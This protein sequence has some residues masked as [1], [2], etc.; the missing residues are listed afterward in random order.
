LNWGLLGEKLPQDEL[1]LAEMRESSELEAPTISQKEFE[2]RGRRFFYEME[3]ESALVKKA[4]PVSAAV[5]TLENA[6]SSSSGAASSMASPTTQLSQPTQT[7]P[8]TFQTSYD[9]LFTWSRAQV[10][11]PAI[12]EQQR[13]KLRQKLNLLHKESDRLARIVHNETA[14]VAGEKESFFSAPNITGSAK[15]DRT[16]LSYLSLRSQS[17][18]RSA[19]TSMEARSTDLVSLQKEFKIAFEAEKNIREQWITL[20]KKAEEARQQREGSSLGNEESMIE[21]WATA[22]DQALEAQRESA[23][24]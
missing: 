12:L 17:T 13:W 6:S 5:A 23:A 21:A 7:Q 20:V 4:A 3:Q 9:G 19:A 24:F 15:K 10:S 11:K 8:Q 18:L 2:A 16:V 14:A 1:L 22:D